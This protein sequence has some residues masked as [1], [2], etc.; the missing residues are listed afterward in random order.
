MSVTAV[1]PNLASAPQIG[2]LDERAQ[3]RYSNTW[4]VE[5]DDVLDGPQVVGDAPGLPRLFSVYRFG[6]DLDLG[7]TCKRLRPRRVPGEQM[8]W[9]VEVEYD[10]TLHT[11]AEGARDP[12]ARPPKV[13]WTTTP[14]QAI[15]W[16]DFFGNAITTRSGEEFDPPA[17]K[18]DDRFALSITRNEYA[19]AVGIAFSYRDTVASDS[20]FG[21]QPFEP[22]MVSVESDLIA[23]NNITYWQTTYQIHFR[24]IITG[25]ANF[26]DPA[27]SP[28]SWMKPWNLNLVNRGYYHIQGGKKLRIK[29]DSGVKD[30]ATPWPLG[31]NGE[32]LAGNT[33]RTNQFL[34]S[35][36]V[37][38]EK[39]FAALGLP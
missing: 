27:G 6:N 23:E 25:G 15:A 34:I 16:H 19:F 31:A 29:D 2:E 26:I 38:P 28:L 17:M 5:T 7:S 8:K 33:P 12:L 1:Y 36:Q 18:D 14:Y 37:H 39:P 35:Y 3:R 30:V 9:E 13:R 10:S 21:F 11:T 20:F 22:K 4:F 24:E 32:R